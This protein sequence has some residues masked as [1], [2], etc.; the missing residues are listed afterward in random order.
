MKRVMILGGGFGGLAAA[1]RLRERL[2]PQDEIILVDRRSHFSFGFRKTWV[3]VGLGSM[4]VG[5]RPLA[6]LARKGI[7]WIRGTVTRIDPQA[8]SVEVDGRSMAADAL[9]VA[10]GTVLAP[11][12]VPGFNDYALNV[13]H[14]QEVQRNAAAL[15]DFSGGQVMVG[16]FSIPYACPPAPFEIAML[17]QAYFKARG[18]R[19]EMEVFSPLPMSLPVLGE[20]GCEV[21]EGRLARQGIRFLAEH[22]AGAV[23]AGAVRFTSGPRPFDLLLGV[24]P[25]RPPQVAVEAGL[26]GADGWLEASR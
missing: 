5:Q 1:N 15:G 22:K 26:A 23:E 8:R 17:V 16:I 4:E 11:E 20:A 6:G 19:A 7:N 14:P 25:H 18:V 24:P 10:L 21:I 3:L 13:Y 9:V 12:Q 2:D